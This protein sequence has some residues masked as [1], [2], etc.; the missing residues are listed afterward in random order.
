MCLKIYI[1][2][3]CR[4]QYTVSGEQKLT[5]KEKVFAYRFK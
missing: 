3:R 4:L 5:K 1:M 2:H